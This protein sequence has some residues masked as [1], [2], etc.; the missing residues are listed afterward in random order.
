MGAWALQ[1]ALSDHAKWAGRDCSRPYRGERIAD[2]AAGC[3][4][5]AMVANARVLTP[6]GRPVWRGDHGELFMEN[7]EECVDKL[8]AIRDMELKS[9]WTTSHRYLH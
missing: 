5:V 1:Q 4:F 6:T 8:K 7:F 3:R 2:P 9:R